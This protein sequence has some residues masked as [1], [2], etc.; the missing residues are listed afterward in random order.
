MKKATVNVIATIILVGGLFYPAD[1]LCGDMENSRNHSE[2]AAESS[3]AQ[4]D[5]MGTTKTKA[6]QTVKSESL[7]RNETYFNSLSLLDLLKR[8]FG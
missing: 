3:Q 4:T 2:F 8:L 6:Q 7:T 1:A 5:E